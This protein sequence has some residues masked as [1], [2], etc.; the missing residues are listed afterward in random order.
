MCAILV[1]GVA[2]VGLTE[3]VTTALRSAKDGEIQTTAAL[4]AAMLFAIANSIGVF[5]LPRSL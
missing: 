2:I 5:M 3:G 1:L 4:L